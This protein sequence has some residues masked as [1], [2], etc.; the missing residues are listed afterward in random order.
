VAVED[1]E[2]EGFLM[3]FAPGDV[4]DKTAWLTATGHTLS[5]HRGD[6]ISGAQLVCTSGAEIV[7][8]VDRSQWLL[9]VTHPA[10]FD[11]CTVP[12]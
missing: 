6:S 1:R 3:R 12:R 11:G 4:R 7:V 5:S 2:V 10:S 9:D 8:T